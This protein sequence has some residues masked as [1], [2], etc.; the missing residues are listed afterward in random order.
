MPI[1]LYQYENCDT[2]RKARKF[3]A[4]AGVAVTLRPIVTQP[5]TVAELTDLWKRSGL[6]LQRFFNT[7]GQ[8]YRALSE[9]DRDPALP[10]AKKLA[11]LA[12][13]GKLLKRP[14]LDDGRR[15]VVGF[16]AAKYAEFVG[17]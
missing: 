12:A 1:T 9:K 17:G 16:D 6:P 4:G 15:V 10:D 5:P 7:S 2:C 8:S 14:L 11:L 3:L 13:D